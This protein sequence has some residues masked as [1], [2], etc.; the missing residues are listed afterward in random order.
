MK[1]QRIKG[2]TIAKIMFGQKTP[3][4]SFENST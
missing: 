4:S 1:L 3:A 2:V